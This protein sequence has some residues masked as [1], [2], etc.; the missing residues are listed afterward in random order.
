VANV[1]AVPGINGAAIG[2]HRVQAGR[3]VMSSG[4]SSGACALAGA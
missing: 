4:N 1:V 2:E 3:N